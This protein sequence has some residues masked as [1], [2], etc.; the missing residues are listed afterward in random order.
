VSL[1]PSGSGEK[2]DLQRVVLAHFGDVHAIG[3]RHP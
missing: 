2:R 3:F 1:L